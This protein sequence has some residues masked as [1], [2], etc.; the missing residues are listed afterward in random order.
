MPFFVNIPLPQIQRK[1]KNHEKIKRSNVDEGRSMTV[2]IKEQLKHAATVI[3]R[4]R[5]NAYTNIIIGGNSK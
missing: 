4:A 1:E 3:G 5:P 2:N